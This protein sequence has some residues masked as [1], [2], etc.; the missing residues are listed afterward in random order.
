MLCGT[1][2][3]IIIINN[4]KGNKFHKRSNLL[5]IIEL[6][7]GSDL[8]TYKL[9]LCF[10]DIIASST[11]EPVKVK[12]AYLSVSVDGGVEG[13]LQVK[14]QK[15]WGDVLMVLDGINQDRGLM[16]KNR[17]TKGDR[18]DINC[19]ALH[20]KFWAT[21]FILMRSKLFEI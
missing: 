12:R 1:V 15:R 21:Y 4:D 13:E 5:K 2:R 10:Q 18:N 7:I 14:Q 6:V 3:I 8:C 16:G 11:V 9:N 17:F 20:L 19:L